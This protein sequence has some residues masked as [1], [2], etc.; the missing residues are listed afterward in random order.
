MSIDRIGDSIR[1]ISR[2]INLDLES[3]RVYLTKE[4]K[5]VIFY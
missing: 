2:L 1:I 5:V 3:Y 4:R